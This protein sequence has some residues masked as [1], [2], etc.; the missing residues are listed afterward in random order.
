MFLQTKN[1]LLFFNNK[2]WRKKGTSNFDN[3]MGSYD[4]AEVCELVAIYML[5]KLKDIGIPLGIYRDDGLGISNK[6]PRQNDLLRKKLISIFKEENLDII[7]KTNVKIIDFL[8]V[9]LNISDN[10]YK[11]YVKPNNTTM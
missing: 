11:P 3:T 10:S 9:T 7:C 2:V 6:T 1:S 5:N 8:D 4:G